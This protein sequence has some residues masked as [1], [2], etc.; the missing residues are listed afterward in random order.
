MQ[1]QVMQ[2]LDIK[3]IQL[4][5]FGLATLFVA[6]IS[7]MTP[8]NLS[9]VNG[10]QDQAAVRENSNEEA[11]TGNIYILSQ[12]KLKI[13]QEENKFDLNNFMANKAKK[14]NENNIRNK[15]SS[16]A[17]DWLGV[18]YKWGGQTK[19]GVDCSAMVQKVFKEN[20]I[21]LP[22]TSFEQFRTGIGIAKASLKKGDLVFFSTAGAGASHVGI[23]IGEGQFI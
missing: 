6:G 21:T 23:F 3:P 19:I 8:G 13:L 12:T 11:T 5:T 9:M 14:E 4:R 22:R 17:L 15:I 1:E 20:G 7:T 16:S 10:L 18:P 2:T